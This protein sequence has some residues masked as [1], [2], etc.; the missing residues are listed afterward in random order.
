M[1]ELLIAMGA[2]F[3]VMT[4]IVVARVCGFNAECGE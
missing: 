2:A 3:W 4:V 1:I